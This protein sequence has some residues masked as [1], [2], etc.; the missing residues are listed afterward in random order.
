MRRSLLAVGLVAGLAVTSEA[1]RPAFALTFGAALTD[2]VTVPNSTTMQD[3]MPTTILVVA[4]PTTITANRAFYM[5]G[6]AAGSSR[7]Y[8]RID[9]SN[10]IGV[11]VDQTSDTIYGS[12]SAP[13][14]ANAI[15]YIAVTI[16]INASPEVHIY[17]GLQSSPMLEVTYG[18]TTNGSG[19]VSSDSGTSAQLFNVFAVDSPLQGDGYALQVVSGVLPFEAIQRWRQNPTRPVL[20]A[21]GA[22]SF[23]ANG[24]GQVLDLTG[25]GNHGTITGAIPS[26]R[27]LPFVKRAA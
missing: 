3:V 14:V 27:L 4:A 25:N 5:K 6:S 26:G 12:S 10:N 13:L 17:H 11:L 1:S 23:G 24:R 8:I 16:D 22:W 15:N 2:R 18:T 7:K 20:G 21:R 9:A 19:G